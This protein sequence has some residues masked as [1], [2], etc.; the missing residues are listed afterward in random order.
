MSRA[1]V[2]AMQGIG[3]SERP[4]RPV[5]IARSPARLAGPS[6][7]RRARALGSWGLAALA[8]VA[9]AA[10]GGRVEGTSASPSPEAS[11][12]TE[13]S[14]SLSHAGVYRHGADALVRIE[15]PHRIGVGFVA[16]PGT[17]VTRYA[18]VQSERV[19][20]VVLGDGRALKVE[21]VLASEP[22]RDVVVLEVAEEGLPELDVKAAQ[23][24]AAGQPVF[25]LGHALGMASPTIT[26]GT[27]D[28][29]IS[30]DGSG[31]FRIAAPLQAGFVGAPVL[32]ASG[33][34]VGV[35]TGEPSDV[36]SVTSAATVRKMLDGVRD[37]GGETM[38]EFGDRTRREKGFTAIVEPLPRDALENCSSESQEW[39]WLE[40]GR[41]LEIAAV[42]DEIGAPEP[43]FRVLEGAVLRLHGDVTDCRDLLGVLKGSVDVARASPD[44]YPALGVVAQTL[45]G[46]IELLFESPGRTRPGSKEEPPHPRPKGP[47]PSIPMAMEGVPPITTLGPRRR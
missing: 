1:A 19:A 28:R 6:Q 26:E 17:V 27:V 10:C 45:E 9:F 33:E 13:K 39:I 29:A 30:G 36:T 41:S 15:T 18:L 34:V 40:L 22:D 4:P 23:T 11:A 7:P 35:V 16:A 38:E 24:P 44:P 12:P 46:V 2:R 25:A 47:G 31:S 20:R 43:A 32:D 14:G 3:S 21:R 5:V 42:M 8:T 37:D